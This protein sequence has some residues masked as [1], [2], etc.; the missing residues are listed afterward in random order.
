MS[1]INSRCAHE[2]FYNTSHILDPQYF[3]QTL[4]H[5]VNSFIV[6]A[7]NTDDVKKFQLH[8]KLGFIK[9]TSFDEDDVYKIVYIATEY[10]TIRYYPDIPYAVAEAF[11][12]LLQRLEDIELEGSGFCIHDIDYLDCHVLRIVKDSGLMIYN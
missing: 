1:W 9:R 2:I 10:I 4:E 7:F 6:N 3:L 5:R 8:L 12:D 11:T